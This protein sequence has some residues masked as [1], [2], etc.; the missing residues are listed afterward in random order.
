[1]CLNPSFIKNPNL[2]LKHIN[3]RVDTHSHFIPIPCGHCSECCA[4]RQA[5]YC[6]RLEAESEYNHFF[7]ATLTYDNKH[8]PILDLE[9][10][11]TEEGCNAALQSI[12]QKSK[13]EDFIESAFD[14][15]GKPSADLLKAFMVQSSHV[16]KAALD[17][18]SSAI[19]AEEVVDLFKQHDTTWVQM[20]YADIHHLQLM[21]KRM[22]DNNTLGR[23]F[24][25]LAVS[26]LG[27]NRGRPHFHI[28]FLVRKQKGDT[29]ATCNSL[30]VSLSKMLQDY[31]SQNVGTRKNPVYE[32]NCLYKTK[33]VNGR[34]FSTFDCHYVNP[35]LTTEGVA[36]VAYYITKYIFKDSER[37]KYRYAFLRSHLLDDTEFAAVWKLIRC[38]LVCSKG[39]GLDGDFVTTEKRVVVA[40]DQP[41]FSNF[42]D[43]RVGVLDQFDDLPPDDFKFAPPATQ[44]DAHFKYSTVRT[45]TLKVNEELCARLKRQATSCTDTCDYPVFIGYNG[46]I[47]PL[48]R[49]YQRRSC[50]YDVQDML[51][52]YYTASDAAIKSAEERNSKHDDMLYNSEA[53]MKIESEYKRRCDLVDSHEFASGEFNALEAFYNPF[54]N[55]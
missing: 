17:D 1:M 2:G 8:L 11:I 22:R 5:E 52:I 26:E 32:H 53:R 24:R 28:L 33:F 51:T 38:R 43:R 23:P 13:D 36:S 46:R 10:P 6:Q 34:R 37:E 41:R 9:I 12:P 30:N 15:D 35:V 42:Y 48:A 50:V 39:L 31:W 40:D 3:P 20:P 14:A 54:F 49:Y 18:S 4:Q 47:F 29:V 21:F 45:R 19:Y 16:R 7:F 44:L 27:S 25:Y 55:I